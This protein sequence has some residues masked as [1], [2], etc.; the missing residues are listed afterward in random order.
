VLTKPIAL[1]NMM[2]QGVSGMYHPRFKGT[3]YEIGYKWG[4]TLRKHGN[5][6]LDNVPFPI[7]EERI[8]FSKECT[9]FYEKHFPEILQE[10][11]GIAEGQQCSQSLLIAVLFSMYCIMP[12]AHCSCFAVKSKENSIL[13]GRNSDFLIEIEKLCM[14]TLYTF[15]T[16][17]F[18]FNG[19]TT[20]FVQM[21]D[22]INQHGLAVG[23]TSVAPKKIKPG[24]NAGMLVRLFLEKCKN[25]AEVISLIKTLPIAS[26]QTILAAD[27]FGNAALIECSAQDMEIQYIDET[28]QAVF[29]TNMFN[30]PK[31]KKHNNLPADTWQAEERYHTL[32]AY[33]SKNSGQVTLERAKGLLAGKVG[34]LCQY[35]R[36]TG[37]DTVWSVI[38]DL[39][40]CSVYRAE[41]NPSRNAFLK[42]E[43]LSGKRKSVNAYNRPAR[44]DISPR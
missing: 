18:S 13:F 20:A 37:K 16:S 21:E 14:N 1:A 8:S 22:G 11:K 25:T 28:M 41:G 33:L 7:T 2:I 44:K 10:I 39:K 38:Y 30:T 26:S 31:M 23:L 6:I 15:T 24:L 4:A 5:M 40:D 34:F 27:T 29:S 36:K 42:D 32:D 35:D 17:S 9:P 3:H 19:N 43:R 12:S